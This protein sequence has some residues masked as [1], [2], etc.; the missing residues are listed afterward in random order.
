MK[1]YGFKPVIE[2]DVEYDEDTEEIYI[3]RLTQE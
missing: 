1:S 3:F 2:Y